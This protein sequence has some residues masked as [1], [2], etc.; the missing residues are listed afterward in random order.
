V[1]GREPGT[2]LS[3]ACRLGEITR[4]SVGPSTNLASIVAE[5]SSPPVAPRPDDAEG[6]PGPVH[7]D[8]P[9]RL[10]RIALE[11]GEAAEAAPD[12]LLVVATDLPA[13]VVLELLARTAGPAQPA[14]GVEGG[15]GHR[16]AQSS[17]RFAVVNDAVT[18]PRAYTGWAF[19]SPSIEARAALDVAFDLCIA[20]ARGRLPSLLLGRGLA[21]AL[22]P[23]RERRGGAL[24]LGLWLEPAERT[25]LDRTRRFVDG[26]LK[27]LR[28]V[29]PTAG[30][31]ARARARLARRALETWESAE[32][33]ARALGEAELTLGDARLLFALTEAHARVTPENVRAAVAAHLVDARR[34][35]LEIHPPAWLPDDP[36][37]ASHR[38]YTIARGD[39]L[40]T[41]AQ[42]FGVSIAALAG[43]NDLDPRRSLT[44]GDALWIPPR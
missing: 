11:G 24:V 13:E 30:E 42:R 1:I 26:T 36:R 41:L 16:L 7:A 3:A 44:P 12:G 4:C 18:R 17:E 38:L 9:S 40:T 39:T 23:V 31:V 28:I 33:R 20:H 29:G 2:P 15:A 19:V 37:L 10:G 25:S 27:A 43:A 35:T 32:L 14:A 8:A 6:D 21:R 22:G 5:T 34:T